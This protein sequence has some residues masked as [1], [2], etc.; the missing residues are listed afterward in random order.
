MSESEPKR[1]QGERKWYVQIKEQVIGPMSKKRVKELI[2]SGKIE[3]HTLIRPAHSKKWKRVADVKGFIGAGK[4]KKLRD[5]EGSPSTVEELLIEDARKKVAERELIVNVLYFL[6]PILPGLFTSYALHNFP[7]WQQEPFKRFMLGAGAGALFAYPILLFRIGLPFVWKAAG[8]L[9]IGVNIRDES[10]TVADTVSAP[11]GNT[12]SGYKPV[13]SP[14]KLTPEQTACACC[15]LDRVLPASGVIRI[16][17][18]SETVKSKTRITTTEH[19]FVPICREC[20]LEIKR[21]T[22]HRLRMIPISLVMVFLFGTFLELLLPGF[23]SSVGKP[24]Y[25]FVCVCT[26]IITYFVMLL[27]YPNRRE[28]DLFWHE[29]YLKS[30]G[31]YDDKSKIPLRRSP[32]FDKLSE[33]NLTL[34]FAFLAFPGLGVFLLQPRQVHASERSNIPLAAWLLNDPELQKKYGVSKGIQI[35]K[36][37]DFHKHK[38]EENS[39]NNT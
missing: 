29:T 31:I 33:K 23:Q 19:A 14:P 9:G 6:A 25:Y 35:A 27:F 20:G 17:M 37:M 13:S 30:N 10:R 5:R 4:K 12:T 18:T 38:W 1:K 11:K 15:L 34:S 21:I 26:A 32:E 8:F 39:S 2:K 3:P 22:S 24:F 7:G 16:E 36:K 28:M